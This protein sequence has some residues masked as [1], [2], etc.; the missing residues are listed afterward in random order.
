MIRKVCIFI[1]KYEN[2]IPKNKAKKIFFK[3]IDSI[4]IYRITKVDIHKSLCNFSHLI[5]KHNET[6]ILIF[7]FI[8][9]L[10]MSAYL[11]R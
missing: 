10:Q 6:R 2:F 9:I 5:C 8:L 7:F 3:A 4:L 11:I 1:I